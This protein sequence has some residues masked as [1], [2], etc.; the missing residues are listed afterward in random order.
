MRISLPDLDAPDYA[1]LRHLHMYAYVNPSMQRDTMIKA[2]LPQTAS[3]LNVSPDTVR[4]RLRSG[5][6]VGERDERGH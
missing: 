3:L 4:R 2:N 6:L 5:S 1:G